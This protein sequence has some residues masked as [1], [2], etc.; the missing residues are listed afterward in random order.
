M[1]ST[2]S[3][4]RN[5]VRMHTSFS[6]D[7]RRRR[8]PS[9]LR[10]V[11]PPRAGRTTD[12][13]GG[14]CRH[15]RPPRPRRAAHTHPAVPRLRPGHPVPRGQL[16][17]VRRL[18]LGR[19]AEV[20]RGDDG[21]GRGRPGDR[22]EP[23]PGWTPDVAETRTAPGTPRGGGVIADRS[24]RGSLYGV[25]ATVRRSRSLRGSACRWSGRVRRRCTRSYSAKC[26]PAPRCPR[27]SVAQ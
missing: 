26:G 11:S 18:L 5:A 22:R 12:S 10:M 19:L 9:P 23:W 1:Y 16:P 25:L 15:A 8:T 20:L 6:V 27:R 3:P 2:T 14:R 24:A 4:M 13:P 21:P 7:R 17:L